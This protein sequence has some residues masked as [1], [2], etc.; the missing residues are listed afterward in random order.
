V[1]VLLNWGA[2]FNDIAQVKFLL[3]TDRRVAF[4]ALNTPIL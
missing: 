4:E 3:P 1:E 2:N